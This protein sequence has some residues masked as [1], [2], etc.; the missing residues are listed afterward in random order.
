MNKFSPS[1]NCFNL[2]KQSESC[3]LSAYLCPAG[4]PTIGY[5]HTK[6]VTITMHCTQSMADKWLQEDVQEIS[7]YINRI[8]TSSINQ[9]MFDAI[10]D[11]VFNVGIGNFLSST[12]L[13]K[14]NMNPNDIT[15]KNEFNK[16]VYAKKKILPGLVIRRDAEVILYFK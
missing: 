9:N 12:L 13:K 14:I 6:G 15:I 7:N 2:I 10:V 5:G 1:I 3:A 8:I 11:F 16:W 4:V